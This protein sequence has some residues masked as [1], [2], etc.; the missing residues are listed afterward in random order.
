MYLGSFFSFH[1]KQLYLFH[2]MNV[3]IGFRSE[4]LHYKKTVSSTNQEKKIEEEKVI[5]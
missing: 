5:S 1:F 3:D 2:L 4:T